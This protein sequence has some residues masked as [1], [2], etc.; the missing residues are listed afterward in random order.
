M[1]TSFIID[2]KI[3]LFQ[4]LTEEE[5][6]MAC[7]LLQQ[8]EYEPGE[9][10]LPAGSCGPEFFLLR[11]GW[12][13]ISKEQAG[14]DEST[15]PI[16]NIVGA[17]FLGEFNG[18]DG[19][20][21]TANVIAL[22]RVS[23]W[24]LTWD[25]LYKLV[26]LSPQLFRNYGEMNA[27]FARQKNLTDALRG[28]HNVEVAVASTLLLLSDRAEKAGANCA[29]GFPFPMSQTLIA[30]FTGHDVAS[31]RKALKKFEAWQAIARPQTHRWFITDRKT[32]QSF[33]NGRPRKKLPKTG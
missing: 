23:C 27:D 12:V 20:G 17:G 15:A 9:I 25:L 10:L 16:L 24:V 33:A 6:H 18:A 7:S 19:K 26:C 31:V 13:E 11:S 14:G 28:A 3:S 32:L 21:C 1:H 8:R 4:K 5:L 2:A 22:T 29:P 30:R